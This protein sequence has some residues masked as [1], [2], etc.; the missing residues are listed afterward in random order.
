M[1][2]RKACKPESPVFSSDTQTLGPCQC[3]VSLHI[4]LI[5]FENLFVLYVCHLTLHAPLSDQ[6]S[7]QTQDA[8]L[9]Q[10]SMPSTPIILLLA[11][12]CSLTAPA[13]AAAVAATN[14]QQP[15]GDG[16]VVHVV[17]ANHLDV[18]F[19]GWDNETLNAYFHSHIPRA[20]SM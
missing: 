19:T 11:C 13:A 7:D 16:A 2:L 15:T 8:I 14:P 6:K 10:P 20:V 1:G 3:H 12:L 4:D 18:G 5:V 9:G 17:F